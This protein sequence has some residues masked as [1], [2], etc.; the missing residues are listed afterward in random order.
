MTETNAGVLAIIPVRAED[1]AKTG[2]MPMLAG[3]PLIDHTFDAA[4]RSRQISRILVTTDSEAVQ[5]LA[6]EFGAEAPFLRPAELAAS[7]VPIERVLQHALAWLEEHEGYRPELVV[8]L[9]IS[10]PFRE[11]GL[12]D[13]AIQTL[14][15]Q[16]LDTVFTAYEERDRFWKA[17]QTGELEAVTDERQTRG[18]R[19]PIYREIS[20]VVCVTTGEVAR[21]GRRIG[22]RV[23]VVAL[24][25]LEAL[26]DTQDPIGLTLAHRLLPD[27]DR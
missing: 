12:I 11:E 13:R 1:L 17:T 24:R 26:V 15:E 23:G 5:Q 16:Q 8:R 10:H 21:S 9:E 22:E 3:R 18:S 2:G 27:E 25:S 4:K 19:A 14:R 6:R 20:G 7:G